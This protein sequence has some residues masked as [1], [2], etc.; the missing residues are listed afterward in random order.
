MLRDSGS[1]SETLS[2]PSCS[3]SPA[4]AESGDAP[5][6]SP[7]LHVAAHLSA[8]SVASVVA[9]AILAS[10][11]SGEEVNEE[12]WAAFGEL[13]MEQLAA[14]GR[15][16]AECTALSRECAAQRT[17]IESLLARLG[18]HSGDAPPSVVEAAEL[19]ARSAQLKAD[20]AEA[21]SA[22]RQ[23]VIAYTDE[24]AALRARVVAV[25][26]ERADEK[27]E[28]EATLRALRE[29][30]A[31]QRESA[32]ELNSAMAALVA[33]QDEERTAFLRGV[34]ALKDAYTP[35]AVTGDR[36]EPVDGKSLIETVEGLFAAM[37]QRVPATI[38]R[39]SASMAEERD[40]S[41]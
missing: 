29:E 36:M 15:G 24:V 19:R 28:H 26:S 8:E 14:V 9:T 31:R 6:G 33:A 3:A 38:E 21:A 37:Q 40:K 2:V 11:Y 39:I 5:R 12:A 34:D 18:G 4:R 7:R 27:T 10:R 1:E 35:D 20:A 17:T 25:E 13:W 30:A 32:A 22:N 23:L 16:R 41:G